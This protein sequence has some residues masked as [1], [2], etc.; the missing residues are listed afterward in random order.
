[1]PFKNLL[2]DTEGNNLKRA[3]MCH[4]VGSFNV[5]AKPVNRQ[6]LEG[7]RSEILANSLK[8][9]IPEIND[10]LIN[11]WRKG[12]SIIYQV[13]DIYAQADILE[14]IAQIFRAEGWIVQYHNQ[15]LRFL[16]EECAKK[17]LSAQINK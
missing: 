12:A 17:E 15:S 7:H 5:G 8:T 9:L 14:Q 4:K 2:N 13:P 6:L 3:E 10:F 11:R 1:M 16:D